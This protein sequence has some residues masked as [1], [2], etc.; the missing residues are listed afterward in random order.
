MNG[1]LVE[2]CTDDTDVLR[3]RLDELAAGGAEIVAVLWQ[4]NRVDSDQSAAYDARGSFV[5]I[6]RSAERSPLRARPAGEAAAGMA[7]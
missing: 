1:H 4:A 2:I 5:I 3:L 7:R 6:A